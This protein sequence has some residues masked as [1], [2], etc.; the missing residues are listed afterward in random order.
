MFKHKEEKEKKEKSKKSEKIK[1]I[2]HSKCFFGVIAIV[3]YD[4]NRRANN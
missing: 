3:L 2:L 1:G 4:K